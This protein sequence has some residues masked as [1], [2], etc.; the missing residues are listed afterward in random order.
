MIKL[1]DTSKKFFTTNLGQWLIFILA[2]IL[3]GLIT[4]KIIQKFN[5]E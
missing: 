1:T 5:K 4:N 2:S 3:A